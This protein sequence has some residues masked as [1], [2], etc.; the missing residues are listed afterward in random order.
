MAASNIEIYKSES[1]ETEISVR[2]ENDSVWLSLAQLVELFQRDKSV[3]SRHIANVFKEKE[4]SEN[5]TVAKIATV[6]KEG[7]KPM[8]KTDCR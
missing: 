5:S 3:L 4:L 6:Q 7:A 1:G 2:L 8:E